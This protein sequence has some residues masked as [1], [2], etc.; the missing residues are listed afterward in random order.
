MEKHSLLLFT[1]LVVSFGVKAQSIAPSTINATGS[2][3]I[4]NTNLYEW[5]IGEMTLVNTFSTSN[6]I[7]TQGVLQPSV[8]LVGIEEEASKEIA[9]VLYPNPTSDYIQMQPDLNGAGKLNYML[10]DNSGKL[11]TQQ[12]IQL[13]SGKEAQQISLVGLPSGSYSLTVSVTQKKETVSKVY[14]I[15][16]IK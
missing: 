7:V 4:I 14:T 9:I 11:I 12:T 13:A 8:S 10:F 2:S 6:L 3:A 15:Q 16:K 5:S 1:V